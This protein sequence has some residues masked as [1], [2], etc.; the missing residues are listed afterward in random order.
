MLSR[1]PL[2]PR[3]YTHGSG[4]TWTTLGRIGPGDAPYPRCPHRE[5]TLPA[6]PSADTTLF[7]HNEQSSRSFGPNC[8]G[9]S[10]KYSIISNLKLQNTVKRDFLRWLNPAVSWRNTDE[11]GKR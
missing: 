10:A 2:L 1:N 4:L 8:R 6:V 3:T 5:A 7:S 11:Q 9:L